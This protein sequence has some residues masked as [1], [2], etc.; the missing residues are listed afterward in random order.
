MSGQAHLA[1]IGSAQPP[2]RVEQA[3]VARFLGRIAEAQGARSGFVRMLERMS[4][5]S[6]IQHRASVL[7]DYGADDPTDF[8]F[9]PRNWALD[10]FPGTRARLAAYEREVVDLASQAARKA[11]GQANQAPSEITHLVV[12]TCTGFFAPGP[13][14]RLIDALGL[15]SSTRRTLVGFMGC[16]AGF[17][18]LRTAMEIVE[19]DPDSSVLVVAA[20]LCSLHLQRELDIS[21]YVSNLLFA[22]GAAAA[23]VTGRSGRAR[24][25]RSHT[26][27]F[28]N[29]QDQMSWRIGDHGFV[30][31]LGPEVPRHLEA[32]VLPFVDELLKPTPWS[33]NDVKGWPVHPGG[34]RVLEAVRQALGADDLP[35]SYDVLARCGN[36]S[37][38]TILF[39]LEQSLRRPGLQ[40]ALGFGPGL[41]M[42]GLLLEVQP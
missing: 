30:M 10:P 20:E 21:T 41:T 26:R 2:N 17:N 11:L 8:E 13:D 29:T 7:S 6:G 23:V 33:R 38:A 14:V 32:S 19:G 18:A 28:P 4:E 35:E 15:P 1:G 3:Q 39:V 36:M 16:Y 9:F 42:E 22:D 24:L 12:S 31:N 34:R 27:V 25:L 40:A 5:R 37:S